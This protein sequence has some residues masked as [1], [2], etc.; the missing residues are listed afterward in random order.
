MFQHRYLLILIHRIQEKLGHRGSGS[1]TRVWYGGW[2]W[3]REKE[4]EF[5]E[6]CP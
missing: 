1:I 2:S 4:M 5:K 6:I 3:V